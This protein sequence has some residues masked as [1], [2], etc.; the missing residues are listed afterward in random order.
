VTSATS[1]TTT[2]AKAVGE[3]VDVATPIAD[4]PSVEATTRHS[5]RPN[6]GG[7]T[8]ARAS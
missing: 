6:A 4:R 8:V 2:T 7:A 1:T 5:D 3:E